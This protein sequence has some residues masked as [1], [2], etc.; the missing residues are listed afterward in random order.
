MYSILPESR[1][2]GDPGGP[3]VR[4]REAGA[5]L[6]LVIWV[7][8]LLSVVVLS[9]AQEWRTEIKLAANFRGAQ[10]CHSLAEAGIYYALAKLMEAKFSELTPGGP[11]MQLSAK[12]QPWIGDQRRH[13]LEISGSQVE[14]RVA[15]EGGKINLNKADGKI[16]ANLFMALG[17]PEDKWRVMVD[18]IEDWRQPGL[19]PR[20]FGA[21]SDYYLGLEPPY[22]VKGGAFDTVEELAWVRGFGG[23]SLPIRLSAYLTVQGESQQVNVNTAPSEVLQ[24]VGVP[25]ALAETLVQEREIA[26]LNVQVVLSRLAAETRAEAGW[27]NL[28]FESSP[29]F[30]ILAT[31]MINKKEGPRHTIKAVVRLLEIGDPPWKF[32]YWADDYSG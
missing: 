16:L 17:I 2:G 12:P 32:V 20:P 5:I 3:S 4:P 24:A 23:S 13:V 7:I 27:P 30:T 9:W 14:V 29:F 6:L 10:Q 26:P 19:L 11:E 31:G 1:K 21:K 8:A 22:P 28:S 15:N 18:S 25:P